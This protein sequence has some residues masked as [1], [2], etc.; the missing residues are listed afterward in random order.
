MSQVMHLDEVEMVFA[1]HQILP[2]IYSLLSL[3]VRKTT[4]FGG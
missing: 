4:L 2:L 1:L 3:L